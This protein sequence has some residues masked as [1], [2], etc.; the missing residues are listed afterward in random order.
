MAADAALAVAAASALGGVAVLRIA[1]GRKRRSYL[2]NVAGWLLLALGAGFGWAA[3]GA[4]GV[5]TVSQFAI[6]LAL[7]LLALAALRSPAA[8]VRASNRRAGMLPEAGEE[9]RIGRRLVTFLLVLILALASAVALAIAL[10]GF[11]LALGASEANANTLA[12]FMQPL[13]WATLSCAVLMT[14]SRNRQIVTLIACA[15]PAIP[16][17]LAGGTP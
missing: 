6:G 7:A 8:R 10:R 17:I 16:A 12:L 2:L 1:W 15:A 5:A 11:A 9:V 14:P 13:A 4:W 3:S